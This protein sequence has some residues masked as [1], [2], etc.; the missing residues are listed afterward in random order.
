[1]TGITTRV[2]RVEANRPKI[3]AQARPEKTG[4][5]VMGAAPMAVV[6]AVTMKAAAVVTALQALDHINLH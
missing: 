4:S 3:R 1:M 2:N 5:S 6:A